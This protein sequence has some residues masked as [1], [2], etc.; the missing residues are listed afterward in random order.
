MDS[1]S[2]KTPQDLEF[3]NKLRHIIH[4]RKVSADQHAADENSYT[5]SLF[6]KGINKIAQ[7]VGEEAVELVIEA[8]DDNR[9]LFKNEAADLI[10]H[11]LVLLEAKSVD[12]SEV[13][14]VLEARHQQ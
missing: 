11:L 2:K 9:E 3:L 14:E 7:K 5:V 1:Q 10:Y 4:Q 13:I 12:L 6:R 8:K